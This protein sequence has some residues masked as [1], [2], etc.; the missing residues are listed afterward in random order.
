M[1]QISDS[2][3][4]PP[5]H[6]IP[7]LRQGLTDLYDG[8][9]K[10]SKSQ[11]VDPAP[12]SIATKERASFSRPDFLVSASAIVTLLLESS[13][14]HVSAF[15]KT[16]TEPVE[17]IACWTCVR[18]MLETSSLA[19]WLHDPTIDARTRVGRAFSLRF[20]GMEQQEKFA[21]LLGQSELD[22]VRNSTARL[23]A[24]ADSLG[25]PIFVNPKNQ[26]TALGQ[27]QPNAT[28]II[29]TVLDEEKKYRLLSAVA[30]GHFW[31]ISQLSF[32]TVPNT[33]TQV[34]PGAVKVQAFEKAPSIMGI[35]FLGSAAFKAL[36]RPF[37]NHSHYFGW[38]SLRLE[39]LFESVADKVSLSIPLRFWRS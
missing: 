5:P 3:N 9:S 38:D 30:H 36:A 33:S 21:A 37:W 23:V 4:S 18:S 22:A 19:A 26:R 13:G 35:G 6:F 24:D 1:S 27:R 15:V 12:D 34:N 8:I 16:I 10:W 7:D 17:P 14:E 31:A 39:E 28:T 25:Y 20:E 32:R 11:C 2:M 29:A